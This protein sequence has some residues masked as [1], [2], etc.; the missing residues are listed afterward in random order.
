M[1]A[2]G[3]TTMKKIERI[4]RDCPK[5]LENIASGVTSANK[6]ERLLKE[7]KKKKEAAKGKTAATQP[8]ET[9]KP[10][11]IASNDPTMLFYLSIVGEVASD[12][13]EIRRVL[14]EQGITL[15]EKKNATTTVFE[16]Q[17]T[18]T[19]SAHSWVVWASW[20]DC[21]LY[22]IPLLEFVCVSLLVV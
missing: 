12:V 9:V 13:A 3:E 17:I 21:C 15:K 22:G 1:A 7:K 11:K 8:T 10:D 19:A 2:V 14:H 6:V 18:I 5:E 16:G 20:R 4:S